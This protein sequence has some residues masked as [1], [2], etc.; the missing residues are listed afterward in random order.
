[1]STWCASVEHKVNGNKLLR[2]IV[3]WVAYYQIAEIPGIIC[4][5]YNRKW[6]WHTIWNT[7]TQAKLKRHIA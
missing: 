4:I 1:M 3:S 5:T 7:V 2:F 6:Y